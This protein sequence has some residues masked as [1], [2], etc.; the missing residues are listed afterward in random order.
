MVQPRS[1]PLVPGAPTPP[2]VARADRDP[3][4]IW[5]SEVILQQTRVDQGMAYWERFVERY[6]T[7]A[8]LA[9]APEDEVLQPVAG[10][11]LLQPRPQPAHRRPAGGERARRAVSPRT[12]R[13]LLRAERRGR[14][15]R[16][17]H[18]LHLPSTCPNRWWT[19]TCTGCW[20]GCSASLRRSTAP[21]AGRSSG[22]WPPACWTRKHPG[23]HNQA[24]MELGATVCTPKNPTVR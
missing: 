12:T 19:A 20:P 22:H 3:Y 23:D 6:P 11:G 16:C 8:D 9:A 7:V 13:H 15:H 24:V 1:A 2:A 10:P 14:I 21:P 18:R 5:L 4:R 17:G